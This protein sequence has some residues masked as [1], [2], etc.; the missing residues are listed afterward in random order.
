[1]PVRARRILTAACVI[2]AAQ[3]VSACGSHTTHHASGIAAAGSVGAADANNNGNYVKAGLMTYQMQVSRELNQ[4]TPEDS[5]YVRG[6]PKSESKLA[7]NQLWFGVFMWAKN[8]TS[9]TLTTSGNFDIVDTQG[10]VYHPLK[11]DP[12]VNPY[13]WE[14]QALA[15]GATEPNPTATAGTG[16]AGGRLLLFKLNTSIYDNRPLTLQ[17]RAPSG[18]KVWG[19][20]SLDL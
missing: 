8:E 11:L 7:P 12:A 1:M 14:A 15:P 13:A 3:F 2:A 9:R 19:T 5:G 10:T 18:K 17:I 16:P 20:I 6:L 4:Y